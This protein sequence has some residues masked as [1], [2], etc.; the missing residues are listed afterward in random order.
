[1][2]K[3]P[4]AQESALNLLKVLSS[5][6]AIFSTKDRTLFFAN[7]AFAHTT[8]FRRSGC[9][10]DNETPQ[11][12]QFFPADDRDFACELFRIAGTLG[13]AYDFERHLRR[14]PQGL[15]LAEVRL[16][17]MRLGR[18]DYVIF[19][20][21][22][23]S[24]SKLYNELKASHAD[25][26]TKVV[27]LMTIKAEIEFG[28]RQKTLTQFGD[29]FADRLLGPLSVCRTELETLLASLNDS[30][31]RAV[32]SSLP[33][34]LKAVDGVI[35]DVVWLQQISR[36]G[37]M[38]KIGC[39]LREVLLSPLRLQ[40]SYLSN[41]G[42]KNNLTETIADLERS[43]AMWCQL[44]PVEAMTCINACFKVAEEFR[45][46][47]TSVSVSC[48][49]AWGEPFSMHMRLELKDRIHDETIQL[50]SEAVRKV[51]TR[52]TK[53][54]LRLDVSTEPG[55]CTL[56]LSSEDA[57]AQ[58]DQESNQSQAEEAKTLPKTQRSEADLPQTQNPITGN[59]NSGEGFILVV[60]DDDD[61]R[62]LLTQVLSRKG[63]EV[64][65]CADGEEAYQWLLENARILTESPC[66]A[67]ICDVR[68][69]R[70]SGPSFFL[71]LRNLDVQVPFIFFSSHNLQDL[72]ADLNDPR[73]HFINKNSSL[74]SVAE[75]VSA[76]ARAPAN[77]TAGRAASGA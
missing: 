73:A 42:L 24:L 41:L 54:R 32:R 61:I 9:F 16:K 72:A 62:R 51:P 44:D 64:V 14:F 57:L 52:H 11:F 77:K 69:P 10:K 13:S 67:I 19:E 55:A 2:T 36:A 60:D 26:R 74:K 28:E 12:E 21:E 47:L 5:A 18:T 70:R 59:D 76:I 8:R 38:S 66:A 46:G 34:A 65:E 20:V 75:R 1:M 27:E 68:M 30:G 6:I 56:K 58:S 40:C 17:K 48:V 39:D 35:Q 4:A 3:A 63:F 37:R 71:E 23:L 29:E 49:C 31:D 53:S 22:D 33:R 50:F 15:I 43:E 7:D 45:T 25:L